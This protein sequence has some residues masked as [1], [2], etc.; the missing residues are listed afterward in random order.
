MAVAKR[1]PDDD[2][3]EIIQFLSIGLDRVLAIGGIGV[4]IAAI[5]ML[6]RTGSTG[7][8]IREQSARTYPDS[9]FTA[10]FY[11]I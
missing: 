8:M 10:G 3:R 7:S 6:T 1:I 11:L 5:F 9:G 2:I 4:G